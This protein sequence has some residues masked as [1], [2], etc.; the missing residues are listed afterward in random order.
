MDDP[1]PQPNPDADPKANPSTQAAGRTRPTLS[2]IDTLAQVAGVRPRVHLRE[3]GTLTGPMLKPLQ[4]GADAVPE[5]AGKYRVQGQVAAG[6][7]GVVYKGH[8]VDLGREVALKFLHERYQQNP[9]LLQRFVE[10]AQIGGQ[11]QHPGIVPVYDL[12]ISGERP[13]FTM[14]FVK[15]RT[16]AALLADRSHSS[17]DR[18]HFLAIFQRICETMAYAHARGVVH[19]DLKPANVMLGAFGE[20]Q[21]VDWGMGKVLSHG[22]KADEERAQHRRHTE[23]SIIETV[24]SGGQG[25]QSIVGSAMG[26]PAY[27]P[28]EQASGDVE[29]MDERSDV[30]SLGAILCEIL[31]GEPPY[32][33]NETERD[34]LTMATRC[35]QAGARERL[36][37]CGADEELVR[38][39]LECLSPA[40]TARPTSAKDV[41]ERVGRFL[42][43]GEEKVRDAQITARAAQRTQKLVVAVGTVVAIALVASLWFWRRADAE[44]QRAETA[45]AEAE[46][47]RAQARSDAAEARRAQQQEMAARADADAKA[48]ALRKAL[49]EFDLLADVVRLREAT[50]AE[51]TL[52]PAWP[53]NVDALEVWLTDQAR[54]LAAALPRIEAAL[55]QMQR[56]GQP[57]RTA[58]DD[59]DAALQFMFAAKAD[60]F[61]HDTLARV[62][63][64]LRAFTATKTGPLA[65]AEERLVWARQVREASVTR[66]A[67]EWRE[68]TAA[69]AAS[70]VYGGLQIEPQI[71]LVPLRADPK[72]RLWEF[73]HLRS[74]APGKAIPR[75]D[76][77]TGWFEITEDTG[78]VFVLVPGGAFTMGAQPDDADGEHY[79]AGA[80]PKEAPPHR[81]EL[82]PFLLSKYELTQAQW[83]RLS[84]GDEPSG[85]KAGSEPGKVAVITWSN[86]VE[87][88]GWNDAVD[89]LHRHGLAVP[90]EAQWELACRGGTATPWSTGAAPTTLQGAANIADAAAQR[91]GVPWQIEPGIDDGHVLHAP[92]GNF[93]PNPF[94]FFDM[95]GNVWEWC[96]DGNARYDVPPRA[97]DG[98]R[99]ATDDSVRINRGGSFAF[100]AT[101]ARSAYRFFDSPQTRDFNLC[102]RPMRPLLA[103]NGR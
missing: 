44:R 91:G 73:A 29:R 59:D 56:R 53:E 81:V 19:R 61:L 83:R 49:D 1:K 95:H 82:A 35:L 69:I 9:A 84:R 75:R 100:P 102:V 47:A 3:A 28:P 33:A 7:V 2:V 55:V 74:G 21:I 76:P 24:R 78:M 93:A 22:G 99:E 92:V 20:V 26:T 80:E 15:G 40:P 77:R 63:A 13:Y 31:T 79:D 30:F 70:D 37:A 41:A 101:R 86:P 98:W 6:G 16:L 36:A 65:A 96:R 43:A 10:E 62:V 18:G 12:G 11:L 48:V 90:T 17:A 5:R 60:Q 64:D 8:D 54:P 68:A 50:A 4:P 39:T 67:R 72:S 25:T 52:Y 23:T 103:P 66:Y 89:L 32:V 58:A 14:K 51:A 42:S 34:V 88:I 97:G 94:G 87:N 45:A 27:M 38:L 57:V 71:G 85:Y 46:I